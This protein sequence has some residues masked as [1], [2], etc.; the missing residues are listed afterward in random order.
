M[1]VGNPA[2]RCPHCGG[3]VPAGPE[4][5]QT[6]RPLPRPQELIRFVADRYGV[7]HLQLSG[8]GRRAIIRRPRRIAVWLLRTIGY[9][10]P[11]IGRLFGKADHTSALAAWRRAEAERAADPECR[12]ETDGLVAALLARYPALAA[13]QRRHAS[14]FIVAAQAAADP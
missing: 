5:E 13:E 1:N 12:L 6:I 2:L 11:E 8:R 14:R 10:L 9:S 3:S 4:E 7:P